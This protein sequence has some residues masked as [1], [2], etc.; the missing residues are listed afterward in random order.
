MI[1]ETILKI[2]YKSSLMYLSILKVFWK[3]KLGVKN[4]EKPESGAKSFSN[5]S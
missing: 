3:A 1:L 2:Y 4:L 5:L